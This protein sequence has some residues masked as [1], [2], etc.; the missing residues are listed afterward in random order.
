M[1]RI[2][3]N[4]IHSYPQPYLEKYALWA[5]RHLKSLRLK[6]TAGVAFK[7]LLKDDVASEQSIHRV[8]AASGRVIFSIEIDPLGL[9]FGESDDLVRQTY[10][11]FND[12]T[13]HHW[14]KLSMYIKLLAQQN[15]NMNIL[16]F[17][18]GTQQKS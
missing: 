3:E 14:R 4:P 2:L 7:N 15:P 17:R 10:T 5:K 6:L 12:E 11:F 8:E 13:S 18:A 1:M 16:D 9:L